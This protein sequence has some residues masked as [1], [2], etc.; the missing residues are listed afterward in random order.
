MPVITKTEK[1]YEKLKQ[2]IET[3]PPGMRM[4]SVR[5]TMA[6]FKVSQVT[7]ERALAMLAR[8]GLIARESSGRRKVAHREGKGGVSS[9]RCIGLAFPDY[10]SRI[11]EILIRLLVQKIQGSSGT[12][13]LLR[14][15]WR[16]RILTRLPREH[17]DGL[18]LMPAAVTLT[19]EDVL[20]VQEFGVP[21]VLF[22][23][24]LR[25]VAVD[26]VTS[27]EEGGGAMMANHLIQLGH[28]RLAVLVAEPAS[29]ITDERVTGFVKQARLHGIDKVNVL[30]CETRLGESS[31]EKAYAK[32]R[33]TVERGGLDFTGLFAVSDFGALGAMKALRDLSI[34][35][36]EQVSVVGFDGLDE[37]AF[38]HPALTTKKANFED[39]AQ[40]AMAI[41]DRRLAGDDGG[42]IQ[43]MITPSLVVRESTG[44]VNL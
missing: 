19:P 42:A 24:V 27:D 11:Y 43:T 35:I 7:V 21:T 17:F 33:D 14:Y 28:R 15:D 26:S 38:F 22:Y 9:T 16:E 6:Q 29:A 12:P 40:A 18:I 13:R 10:P 2:R 1:I 34:G 41:L 32:I 44:R 5:E 36:P 8:E 23:H 30:D 3:S 25:G 20:K 37:S 39:L 4:P 31:A